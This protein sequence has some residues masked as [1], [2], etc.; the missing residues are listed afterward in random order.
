MAIHLILTI[1]RS[2]C[3]G[4]GILPNLSM[5]LFSKEHKS[6]SEIISFNS[7][8]NRILSE[9]FEIYSSGNIISKSVSI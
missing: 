1:S 6:S 4:C 3:A 7:L 8:Y 9:I 5:S 2:D